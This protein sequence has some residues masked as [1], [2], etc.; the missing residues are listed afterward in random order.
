MISATKLVFIQSLSSNQISFYELQ[1]RDFDRAA[2]KEEEVN[3]S[4]TF[5]EGNYRVDW[6]TNYSISI[7]SETHFFMSPPPATCWCAMGLFFCLNFWSHWIT[8]NGKMKSDYSS[9]IHGVRS[10]K[11]HWLRGRKKGEQTWVARHPT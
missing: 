5:R 1:G 11:N 8:E 3:I 2:S 7:S 6:L 10:H 4:H 9:T